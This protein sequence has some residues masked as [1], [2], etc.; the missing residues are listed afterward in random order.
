MRSIQGGNYATPIVHPMAN[1]VDTYRQKLRTLDD[2]DS[3]LLQESNLP[4]PRGNLELA[5]AV[6]Q[7]GTAEQFQH[8]MSFGP[9]KAP[10]NS[11]YEFLA[12]C[13]VLGQGTLLAQSQT[14]ALVGLCTFASDPRW[15]IREAVAQAL[16]YWGRA[17]MEALLEAMEVWGR[18][19]PLEQRAAAAGLCEP[20]LLGAPEH[21]EKVQRLLDGITESIL[22]LQNR[23]DE[24]FLALR[25]GLGYCW[26]V[27][28]V[29]FPQ[30]G[31]PLIE[32]WFA[33]QDRDIVWIMKQ[34]LRKKRLERMDAEWVAHWKDQLGL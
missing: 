3:Y 20:S 23:R 15:R 6:A 10:T 19:S 7:E 14:N 18:G 4:G 34:N 11:P 25:K 29:A 32:K 17:D 1:K 28:V 24:G 13:G 16:Q 21:A 27:A 26:S 5:H 22:D 9:D 12:F 31:K 2:W 8:L 33:T 30:A